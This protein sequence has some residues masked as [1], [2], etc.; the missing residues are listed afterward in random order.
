MASSGFQRYV[1]TRS[2]CCPWLPVM[3]FIEGPLV[4]LARSQSNGFHRISE[5]RLHKARLLPWVTSDGV[6][7]GSSGSISSEPI[8]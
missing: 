6:Y 7:R 8:K 1:Y 5:V 2:V 3:G 4:L